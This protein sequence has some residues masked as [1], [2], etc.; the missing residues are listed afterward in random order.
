MHVQKDQYV[1]NDEVLE[2]DRKLL[3]Y[4]VLI[5][6]CENS[7]SVVESWKE[8][9]NFDDHAFHRAVRDKMNIRIKEIQRL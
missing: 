9:N 3:T 2:G 8:R 4:T 5:K 1:T 7:K 6:D